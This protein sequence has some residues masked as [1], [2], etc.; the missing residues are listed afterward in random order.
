MT[1]EELTARLLELD[2]RTTRH[3]EQIKTAFNRIDDFKTLTESVQRL[4][5]TTELIAQEMK[6][7]NVRVNG[8]S[9]D[10]EEIKGKPGKRWDSAVNLILTV[11]VT[12]LLTLLLARMGLK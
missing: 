3:T 10:M 12:A 9:E 5:I 8:L 1:N 4:A 7:L 6:G 11:I 2:E